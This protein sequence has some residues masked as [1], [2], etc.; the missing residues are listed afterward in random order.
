MAVE[1]T[2]TD[3]DFGFTIVDEDELTIVTELQA[4]KEKVERKVT[5]S[6]SEKEKLDNKINT[7]YNM[8]QP[9]L[10][11]LAQ[12]P[13]KDYI[14]WP[15]RLDKIEEFRHKIDSVYKG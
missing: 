2:K 10:N 11:N 7:L 8:F 9:L 5:L 3:F 13:E 12:N 6:S 4:E 1:N 14:L 15:N